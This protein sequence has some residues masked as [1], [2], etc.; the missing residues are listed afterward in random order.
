MK[1][2]SSII[3]ALFVIAGFSYAAEDQR[4]DIN[5]FETDLDITITGGTILYSLVDDPSFDDVPAHEGD[6]ALYGE[7]DASLGAYTTTTINF[8]NAV[9][10]TDMREL[11]FWIYFLDESVPHQSGNFTMRVMTQDGSELGSPSVSTSG[12]WH[13]IIL[14]IDRISAESFSS[15]N[16]LRFIWNPGADNGATGKFYIDEIYGVRPGNTPGVREELVYG[17]NA[18]DPDTGYPEGWT[19]READAVDLMIGDAIVEP[20]EGSDYMESLMPGGWVRPLETI[21]AMEDFDEWENVVEVLVDVRMSEDFAGTWHNFQL[22]FE[23]SSG[24]TVTHGIRSVSNKDDW[25]TVAWDLDMTPHLASLNDPNGWMRLSF[26]TQMDAAASGS[27][28]I[29]NLRYGVATTYVIGER[30]ISASSYQGGETF[31]VELTISAEGDVQDYAVIENT[32]E[33][34]EVSEI[35]D[36]GSFADGAINWAVNLGSGSKSVSYKI[37][38]PAS[39]DESVSFSGTVG[40]IATRGMDSIF[41]VFP[42]LW[43]ARVEC[44]FAANDVVLDGVINADEY[45]GAKS[46]YFDHDTSDGNEAP[47]VHISGNEYP[48]EEQN[49]TFYVQ[50][51]N[52]FIYVACDVTDSNL[53]FN[54]NEE[55]AWNTDSIEVFLDGNLSRVTD[56]EDGPLGIQCTVVGD[57]HQI[58]G[59]NVPTP[60][61]ASGFFYSE[62]G[63][64]W[65]YGARVRDDQSGYVV[66]YQFFK[67]T[68]LAPVDRDVLG[69]EILMNDSELGAGARTGKWG[70]HSTKE[71][72]TVIEAHQD[73]TGWALMELLPN[74]SPVS[75]WGLY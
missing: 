24:G 17:L 41:Y 1:R 21:Q 45:A 12:E 54:E 63:S 38:A 23:S 73:E 74:D 51:D 66:E 25:R 49:V 10:M 59:D 56:R 39:G 14:P 9:D 29:D 68:A 13:H 44:P 72:G 19:I 60:V 3:L 22:V 35:S 28:Y 42:A 48:A 27:V 18:V 46:Y 62:D 15:F 6:Y 58:G 8:P 37:T 67:E 47:G 4:V 50:H 33:G 70:F 64:V 75:E 71:D 2:L 34:W 65:N 30:T 61:E 11:H 16:Q 55:Q 69:F 31:D 26:I 7:Y 36:S 52:E 20:S 57:G 43:E 40:G 32:P 53:A 5:N